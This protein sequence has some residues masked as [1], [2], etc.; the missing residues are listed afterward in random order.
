[1]TPQ[2]LITGCGTFVPQEVID[3]ETLVHSYNV[4]VEKHNQEYSAE[5]SVGEKVALKAS[6]ADFIKNSSGIE[7]RHVIEASGIIDPCRMRPNLDD[8]ALDKLSYQAEMGISAVSKALH[9]ANKSACDVGMLIS[10]CSNYERPYPGL[11][12][13]VQKALGI[14]GFAFDMNVACSS[15]PFAIRLAYNTLITQPELPGVIIVSPEFYTGHLNFRDRDS[16]FIFG[17]AAGALFLERSETSNSPNSFSIKN[18]QLQTHFSNNIRND[19]GFLRQAVN[20]TDPWHPRNLFSQQGRAVFKEI[21]PLVSKMIL[22]QLKEER[23]DIKAVKRIWLHQANSKMNL[24]L[25]KRILGRDPLTEELPLVLK[26]YG[27]TGAAGVILAF[28]ESQ[29]IDQGDCGVFCAFGAGY[30]AGSILLQ[31]CSSGVTPRV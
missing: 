2:I 14:N 17:D 26:N 10:V 9:Q 6:S 16:H 23:V 25:A 5:I 29:N 22:N 7:E 27:N 1:L 15:V 21:V 12:I 19:G 4:Y 30:S 28:A 31:K 3:N 8:R 18:I 24:L 20:R 13:E 11:A